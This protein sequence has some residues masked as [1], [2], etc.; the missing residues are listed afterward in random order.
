M[1]ITIKGYAMN[2]KTKKVLQEKKYYR[3]KELAELLGIGLSTVWLYM[4]KGSI[5]PIKI[6][7]RVTIFDINEVTKSLL[8]IS[9]EV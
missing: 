3:A 1:V 5:K 2:I 4:K 7:S 6:S 9:D 8:N